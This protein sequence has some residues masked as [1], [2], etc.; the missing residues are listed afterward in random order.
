M[1]VYN[2]NLDAYPRC[3][4]PAGSEL[5]AEWKKAKKLLFDDSYLIFYDE[6][7]NEVMRSKRGKSLES[8]EVP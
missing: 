4:G 7:W 2:S 8:I 6:D 3:H 1:N 5:K